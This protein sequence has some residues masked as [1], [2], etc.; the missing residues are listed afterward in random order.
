MLLRAGGGERL[1]AA[2]TAAPRIRHVVMLGPTHRVAVR[3]FS[4]S[5]SCLPPLGEV[6]VTRGDWEPPGAR[7]CLVDDRPRAL[8]HCL[9]V[10]CP[11]CR[12]VSGSFEIIPV[13]VGDASLKPPASLIER[14]WGGPDPDPWSA[15]TSRALPELPQ[16]AMVRPRRVRTECSNCAP[17]STTGDGLPLPDPARCNAER[18]R[19]DHA[20]ACWTPR[21]SGTTPR[22]T[23]PRVVGG[24]QHRLL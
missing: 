15:R 19:H 12:S 13:L 24:R 5:R 1:C 22:A 6:P 7:R 11:S 4:L 2:R 21:N 20:A 3:N 18:R 23:A 8:G 10:R 14:L 17:V 16:G 9:E